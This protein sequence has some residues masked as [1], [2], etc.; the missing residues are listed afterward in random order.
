MQEHPP[1]AGQLKA[2]AEKIGEVEERHNQVVDVYA[3]ITSRRK[4]V[5]EEV[6]AHLAVLTKEFS[7][8]KHTLLVKQKHAQQATLILSLLAQRE[9][10]APIRNRIDKQPYEQYVTQEWFLSEL[11]R[12]Q[13]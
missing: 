8:L 7:A 3:D 4:E 13:Q 10:V 1:Y 6:S 11:Q 5:H 9:E 2:I 12:E